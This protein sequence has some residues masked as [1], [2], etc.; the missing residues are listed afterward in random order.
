MSN[1]IIMKGI[2]FFYLL[3][4]TRI[5]LAQKSHQCCTWSSLVIYLYECNIILR[6][7]AG[8]S[9]CYITLITHYSNIS[10]NFLVQS[11]LLYWKLSARL[12][13]IPSLFLFFLY[14]YLRCSYDISLNKL[15]VSFF[16][17]CVCAFFHVT[18]VNLWKPIHEKHFLL[19]YITS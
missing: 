7:C 12:Y 19:A 3:K 1:K 17:S 16:H 6:S 9:I 18:F 14:C 10:S 11:A 8:C 4:R 15:F 13:L 5:V 2:I